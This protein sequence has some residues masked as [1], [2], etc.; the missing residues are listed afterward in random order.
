MSKRRRRL[1]LNTV[2]SVPVVTAVTLPLHA[3]TTIC[4]ESIYVGEWQVWDRDPS[5][6]VFPPINYNLTLNA[7][8]NGTYEDRI[9]N[10]FGTLAWS[11]S[12]NLLNISLSNGS[13]IEIIILSEF[14]CGQGPGYITYANGDEVRIYGYRRGT[15]PID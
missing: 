2:W 13:S 6:L 7:D 5:G 15:G 14:Y 9:T 4:P 3:Q 1:L 11:E 8:N 12:T 10:E